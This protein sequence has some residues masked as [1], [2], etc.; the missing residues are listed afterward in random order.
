MDGTTYT[1][2]GTVFYP[3]ETDGADAAFSA[4]LAALGPAPIVFTAHG[5]HRTF[6]DPDNHLSENCGPTA[7]FEEIPNH[8]GYEYLQPHPGQDGD[9]HRGCVLQRDEL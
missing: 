8:K 6:R 2:K 3:A 5:N 4:R 1:V 9:H 7:G